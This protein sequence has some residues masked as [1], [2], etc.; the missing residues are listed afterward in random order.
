M[1]KEAQTPYVAGR[2]L[3]ASFGQGPTATE[4]F[5]DVDLDVGA[6]T[7]AAITGPSGSG[8]TTLLGFVAG[9]DRPTA[10]RVEVA[11]VEVSA[12]SRRGAAGFR[13]RHVGIV[14][15]SHRLLQDLTAGENVETSLLPLRLGRRA[16]LE[17]VQ[18]ALEQVGLLDKRQRFPAELSGGEQQRV[19]IARACVKQPALLLADEPTGNLDEAS[20][21]DV[22]DAMFD[23][24]G[25]TT[26]RT[27]IIVTHDPLV[28]ARAH[29][30]FELHRTGL[31]AGS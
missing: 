21:Q 9:L 1:T 4:V 26:G 17:R 19:S 31:R 12:L 8:K 5:R 22:L 18:I 2:G 29:V 20:S 30:R 3:C 11:G 25:A 15:Q 7:H 23:L 14:F 16:R 27:V 24:S 28:A 13:A 6:G 10:G